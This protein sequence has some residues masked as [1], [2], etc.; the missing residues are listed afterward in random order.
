MRGSVDAALGFAWD[1]VDFTSAEVMSATG[2]TRSTAI[3]ALNQLIE[4]GLVAEL[5][6][7]RASGSYTKGRPA[8]RF[9]LRSEAGLVLGMD[10][11]RAHLTVALADLRGRV[12]HRCTLELGE[13]R[14]GA[15]DRR[16]AVRSAIT[17]VLADSGRAGDEVV[18]ACVGVPAPVDRDGASPEDVSGFW[19]RMNPGLVS[20]LREFAPIVRVE[21][22]ASLAA[23][24][25][26]SVGAATASR[27]YV[28]LMAGDRLGAG[29]VLD[30][31][32]LRGMHGG[33]GEMSVL[34]HVDGVGSADG[35]GLR[36][37]TWAHTD[38]VAGDLPADHPWAGLREAD[39][40]GMEAVDARA[41]VE[42]ARDGDRWA[43]GLTAR[44]AQVLARVTTLLCSVYDPE[45]V[46][47]SGGAAEGLTEVVEQ[48]SAL[49]PAT[50]VTPPPRLVAS[51]LGAQVVTTG[52]VSG[53]VEAAR[54]GVLRIPRPV[55]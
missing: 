26:G 24:A 12:L 19:T 34:D 14:D 46:V 32:L 27:D 42:R 11:G 38:I 52:A 7:A 9:T 1:A 6:N 41:V 30:G 48:A 10:A 21:N 18:A 13:D 37:A 17:T 44:A 39:V 28:A 5:P 4:I 54:A 15:V 29:V 43:Q 3:E 53:A 50:V 55:G 22:D 25:E 45:V 51:T 16:A 31:R 36:L 35:F 23:L 49:L 47:V 40:A 2:L 20:L 8:R 33:A